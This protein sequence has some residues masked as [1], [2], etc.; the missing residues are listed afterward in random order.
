MKAWSTGD[1]DSGGDEWGQEIRLT[2]LAVQAI[3]KLDPKPKFFVLC[4]DLIH[5]MPEEQTIR[6]DSL[7]STARWGHDDVAGLSSVTQGLDSSYWTIEEPLPSLGESLYP[8]PS[9]RPRLRE[10]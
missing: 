1:C 2:E 7:P 3:N 6:L 8:Q 10:N 9:D 5:A 4:G